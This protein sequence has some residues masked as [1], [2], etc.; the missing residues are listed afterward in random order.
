MAVMVFG[1]FSVVLLERLIIGKWMGEYLAILRF[2]LK[3]MFLSFVLVRMKES[4][5][6]DDF[7]VGRMLRRKG[8][9]RAER[10]IYKMKEMDF[11]CAVAHIGNR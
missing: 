11:I 8:E 7:V 1:G 4:S 9:A 10:R 6:W 2:G 3:M 5:D